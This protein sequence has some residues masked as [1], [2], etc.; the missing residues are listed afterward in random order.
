M[1]A[2]ETTLRPL[3]RPV[4]TFKV[5]RNSPYG[6]MFLTLETGEDYHAV[7]D[8][9]PFTPPNSEIICGQNVS[10]KVVCGIIFFL[11]KIAM[12]KI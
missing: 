3:K 7:S 5:Q 11:E 4:S 1:S 9:S 8:F 12:L 6:L 2:K 10:T